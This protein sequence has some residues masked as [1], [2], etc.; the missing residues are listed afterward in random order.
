MPIY[1]VGMP[2]VEGV[3]GVLRSVSGSSSPGAGRRV[4]AL[5][6][7]MREEPMVYINGKPFVLREEVGHAGAGGTVSCSDCVARVCS[8]CEAVSHVYWC[9]RR[10]SVSM[11]NQVV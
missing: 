11:G 5:W 4:H 9:K 8:V 3:R 1:G 6:V 2:T 7:N 10:V